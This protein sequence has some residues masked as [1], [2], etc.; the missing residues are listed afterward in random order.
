MPQAGSELG[1]LAQ[2]RN[3]KTSKNGSFRIKASWNPKCIYGEYPTRRQ[4]MYHDD[5]EQPFDS[6]ES[7]HDFMHV[8]A[9][10]ILD[11]MKE[12]KSE[13]QAALA[14]DDKRR[15]QAIELAMFK[16][17]LL[18]CHVTK[19]RRLLNDLRTIRRLILNE[20]KPARRAMTAA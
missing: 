6:I 9:E 3:Q 4:D 17:K 12:V 15:A 2:E 19:S 20:R 7:A 1:Q 11:A 10:T 8:L 16:L 5:I 18:S 14:E 13:H